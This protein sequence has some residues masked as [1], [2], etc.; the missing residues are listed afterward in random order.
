MAALWGFGLWLAVAIGSQGPNRYVVPALPGL[1]VLAGFGLATVVPP[2]APGRAGLLVA[3]ALALALPGTAQ[4]LHDAAASGHQR[5]H[6]Q[7]TLAAA[8]P[9]G[10][11][12]YG[13]YAPTMLF[14][15]RAELLT[16]WPS[17][18]ANTGDPVGR[19]GVT[20]VL[21]ATAGDLT[22]P[23]LRVAG[24]Q[25]LQQADGIIQV[26]WGHHTLHP[27]KIPPRTPRGVRSEGG[28]GA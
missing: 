2:L 6:G 7:R 27:H 22:D 17:A 11:V 19:F 24:L 8:L 23:T 12:V 4:Y 20:H 9:E 5:E 28:A 1:A 26:P 10:A 14:D 18:G 15:T 21:A 13:A 16:L 3:L 25:P